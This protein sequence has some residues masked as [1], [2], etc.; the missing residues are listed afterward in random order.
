VISKQTD[1]HFHTTQNK[2]GK[3]NRK[4]THKKWDEFEYYRDLYIKNPNKTYYE[5]YPNSS[6]GKYIVTEA[7]RGPK[8]YLRESGFFYFILDPKDVKASYL[9]TPLKNDNNWKSNSRCSY[10]K[11]YDNK[12]HL[13]EC[14]ITDLPEGLRYYDI[15]KRPTDYSSR[16]KDFNLETISGRSIFSS[17]LWRETSN[18]TLHDGSSRRIPSIAEWIYGTNITQPVAPICYF[19]TVNQLAYAQSSL[20]TALIITQTVMLLRYFRLDEVMGNLVTAI[21]GLFKDL[22]RFLM[23]IGLV[24][25]PYGLIQ[26]NFIYPNQFLQSLEEK[27]IFLYEPPDENGTQ[28]ID[29]TVNDH[30]ETFIDLTDFQ[31]LVQKGFFHLFGELLMTEI[32]SLRTEP[33][34]RSECVLSMGRIAGQHLCPEHHILSTILLLVYLIFVNILLFNMLIALFTNTYQRI[35]NK[36]RIIWANDRFE[37]VMSSTHALPFSILNPIA[38]LFLFVWAIIATPIAMV[39]SIKSGFK[40]S[41]LV[42]FV[43]LKIWPRF[44]MHSVVTDKRKK[45]KKEK[46]KL[47]DSQSLPPFVP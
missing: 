4:V 3:L 25:I 23:I 26:E 28:K 40:W 21:G 37:M 2:T 15:P 6:Q 34:D 35:Q 30:E 24:I 12:Y 13:A 14:C 44:P 10:L 29:L 16:T 39:L 38:Q 17:S 32:N 19:Q 22:G 11:D 20:V 7:A 45:L 46:L 41:D 42:R 9:K 18:E 1:T 36:S 27:Y 31:N 33:P 5:N 47:T 43:N 8:N